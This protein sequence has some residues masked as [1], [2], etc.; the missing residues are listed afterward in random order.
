MKA[1]VLILPKDPFGNTI[2]SATEG[3]K[4]SYNF[5]L[6][7]SH[8]NASVASVLNIT[9]EGWNHL[10]YL[11]I[12][13]IVAM[14]GSFLLNVQEQTE[15]LIG[16]PLPLEVKPGDTCKH[17][18]DDSLCFQCI[19]KKK[20]IWIDNLLFKFLSLLLAGILEVSNCLLH[21]NIT[22]KLFQLFSVMEASIHQLDL[23]GN[24]VPGWY[25][26]DVEVLQKGSNLSV[27]ISD[28][29]FKEVGLGIQAFSFKLYEPGDFILLV[30][31]KGQKGENNLIS[32]V[33][34][35]FTVY[36]GNIFN[37]SS[38]ISLDGAFKL[39]FWHL[40]FN[41]LLWWENQYCKWIWSKWLICWWNCKILCFLKRWISVSFSS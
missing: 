5:S 9:D 12:E 3:V 22:T 31:R 13:F 32:N 23:Y 35:D 17:C 1:T 37:Y 26:F 11:S 18:F 39:Q 40:N 36:I 10:G 29:L 20:K 14:S 41:R 6:S 8:I 27:P 30:S 7:I 33:P 4:E 15:T 24:P 25:A 38:S 2:S 34:Y 28:L 21:F 19:R 16:S